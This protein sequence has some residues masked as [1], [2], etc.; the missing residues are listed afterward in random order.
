MTV[1]ID[2][3]NG[4]KVE[5]S[6][7]ESFLFSLLIGPFFFLIKGMIGWFFLS[8]FLS[9]CTFGIAWVP[10]AFLAAPIHRQWLVGRGFMTSEYAKKVSQKTVLVNQTSV[11]IEP[12]LI[13]EI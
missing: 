11:R 2:P 3:R 6:Y 12:S 4:H 1:Y 7:V 5:V 9:V 10:L 8:L 13:K